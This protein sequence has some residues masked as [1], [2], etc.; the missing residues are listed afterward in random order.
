[1]FHIVPFLGGGEV[2]ERL[3]IRNRKEKPCAAHW[4][5]LRPC[6]PVNREQRGDVAELPPSPFRRHPV[7]SSHR[8]EREPGLCHW[9]ALGPAHLCY[10]K[11]LRHGVGSSM[12]CLKITIEAFFII[13]EMKSV[14]SQD[15]FRI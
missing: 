15:G 8:G 5:S 6:G 10:F 3:A 4:D 13:H 1:M 2:G 12:V 9:L 14:P 11:G 7:P